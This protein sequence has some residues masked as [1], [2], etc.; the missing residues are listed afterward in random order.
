MIV[1]INYAYVPRIVTGHIESGV[2]II[3]FDWRF[4]GNAPTEP[5]TK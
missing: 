5:A 4:N 3:W 2:L 1:S